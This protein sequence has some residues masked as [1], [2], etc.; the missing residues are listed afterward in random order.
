MCPLCIGTAALLASSGTS[1]GGL[2]VILLGRRARRRGTT[3]TGLVRKIAAQLPTESGS[4]Q[5][6]SK[7]SRQA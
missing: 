5:T 2:G 4:R 6:R 3:L 7:G 1:A